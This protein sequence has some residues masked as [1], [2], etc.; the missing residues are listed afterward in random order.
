[1]S[2]SGDIMST[3]VC[4]HIVPYTE[5]GQAFQQIRQDCIPLIEVAGDRIEPPQLDES[6][7]LFSSTCVINYLLTNEKNHLETEVINLKLHLRTL[8]NSIV[9]N[10]DLKAMLFKRILL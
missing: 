5:Q 4:M 2:T 6:L 9:I 8:I 3:S 7:N 1:M 10:L